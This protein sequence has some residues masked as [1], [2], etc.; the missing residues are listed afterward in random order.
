MGELQVR[1]VPEAFACSSLP[2]LSPNVLFQLPDP[3][4]SGLLRFLF[5]VAASQ[6]SLVSDDRDSCEKY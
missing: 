1:A 6:I 2:S 4:V 3:I 5:P